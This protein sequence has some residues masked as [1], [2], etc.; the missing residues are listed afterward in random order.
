MKAGQACPPRL[1]ARSLSRTD[2]ASDKP[3]LQDN[4][5]ANL[6]CVPTTQIAMPQSVG[7]NLT[8][9]AHVTILGG[10]RSSL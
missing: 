1:L 10:H 9:I 2:I 4:A 7:L 5:A 8:V 6:P 3:T